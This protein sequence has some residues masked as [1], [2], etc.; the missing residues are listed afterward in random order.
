MSHTRENFRLLKN[1]I[2]S[3]RQAS[4]AVKTALGE[5]SPSSRLR[6]RQRGLT[7]SRV[8]TKTVSDT[9]ARA[10]APAITFSVNPQGKLETPNILG[11]ARH[12]VS[13]FSLPG[14]RIGGI[15]TAKATSRQHFALK[16]S[17]AVCRSL[18][19]Q[20]GAQLRTA[21][22]VIKLPII[23]QVQFSLQFLNSRTRRKSI[24]QVK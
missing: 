23:R 1:R 11:T 21:E 6:V 13:H 10:T 17:G 15:T 9:L 20:S 2:Q 12:E 24:S 16:A 14:E 8:V 4:A 22:S 3:V 18:S 5:I 19:V 7:T